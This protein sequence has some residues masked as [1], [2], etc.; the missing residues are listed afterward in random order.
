MTKGRTPRFAVVAAVTASLMAFG[1]VALADNVQNDV[2]A[3]GNDTI[4]AGGSTN[5]K[6]WIDNTSAGGG[7]FSTCDPADG[8]SATV[9]I[10]AP[11]GVTLSGAGAQGA[12]ANIRLLTFTACG[13]A[14]T[15]TQTVTF[16]SSVVGD[17]S[18]ATAVS[19]SRGSYNPSPANFTLHV[20]APTTVDTDADN[21]GRDDDVDNCP[22]DVNAD[23]LDSDGDGAG[24]ACDDNSFAPTVSSEAADAN[25]NEGD[26]LQ[27]S[28]AFSDQDPNTTL[29]I[30]QSSG[31]GVV[32]PGAT[33]GTWSWSL[34]TNDDGSGTV[35]VQAS[36][37]EKTVTDS[38]DWS[39]ANVAPSGTFNKPSSNV[40]EGSSFNVSITNVTDASSADTQAGFTYAFDC[41]DGSGY[42]SFGTSNTRTCTNAT[43]GPATLNVGGKVKDK[44]GD[45]STYTGT[46]GVANVAP[47]V[48]SSISSS[49]DCNANATL[50]ISF[51]D[52]G[53]SDRP[54]AVEINWGD[55]STNTTFNATDQGPQDTRTHQY[56]TPG[57]YTVTVSV[58]DKD[59]ET[60]SDSDAN[61]RVTV[62]QIYSI[63][64][65][66]PFTHSTTD[67]YV[68]NS[69]KA[70]RTV[71]VKVRITDDCTGQA[72]GG[73]Q[74]AP[75]VGIAKTVAPDSSVS[76]GIEAYA[77]AG[78]SNA[79]DRYFRWSTD[80]FWIYNLD[81]KNVTWGTQTGLVTGHTYRVDVFF[82]SVKASDGEWGL[83]KMVK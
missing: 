18:I 64:Y 58:T 72:Y 23:Q 77:D 76:D 20:N 45:V 8:S 43:D 79:N 51:S 44:D 54:W 7:A 2:V 80:G 75:S 47:T 38:F 67:S 56:S 63:Q 11:L 57:Q 27:T 55:G 1:G 15:N 66:E 32:T 26:T 48:T 60:G 13:N 31:A 59:G 73:S 49:V 24:N 16:S 36:D 21:D 33:N 3:N 83:L 62:R 68:I 22:N 37:G 12:T 28:G 46:V 42:G 39:A 40:N 25:G 9:T 29:T 82:G 69:A 34:N 14:T 78:A 4:T 71:P 81:T 65:L 6:Y 61:N 17:H 30:T 41:G 5:I 10:T 53:T 74:S 52:P 50:S 70:G 19:D 35:V